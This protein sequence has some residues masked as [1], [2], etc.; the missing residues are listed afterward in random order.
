MQQRNPHFCTPS[1]YAVVPPHHCSQGVRG[2]PLVSHIVDLLS[3]SHGQR[4]DHSISSSLFRGSFLLS[5][6][7]AS[8]QIKREE[9]VWCE[10]LNRLPQ[11]STPYGHVLWRRSCSLWD[12][13]ALTHTDHG[14]QLWGMCGKRTCR[15]KLLQKSLCS[16]PVHLRNVSPP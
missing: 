3:H 2:I 5:A 1:I 14:L 16:I 12:P 9:R 8:F 11:V 13:T 7:L 6:M 15:M 4:L 10:S